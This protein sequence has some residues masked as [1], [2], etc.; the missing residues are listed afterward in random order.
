MDTTEVLLNEENPLSLRSAMVTDDGYFL[1]LT[2]CAPPKSAIPGFETQRSHVSTCLY[3][4]KRS[5]VASLLLLPLGSCQ[6]ELARLGLATRK[7]WNIVRWIIGYIGC[8]YFAVAGEKSIKVNSFGGKPDFKLLWAPSGNSVVVF[9]NG[10]P[11]AFICD[12]GN[13]LRRFSKGFLR[14]DWLGNPW[15]QAL[16]EKEFL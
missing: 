11:W 7:K 15:D 12:E 4:R 9:V 6:K 13:K 8:R 5:L 10:E 14:P 3:R 2:L 16:Y 1:S